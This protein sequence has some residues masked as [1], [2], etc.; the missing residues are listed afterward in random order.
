MNVL[1]TG[2]AGYIGKVVVEQLLSEGHRVRVVD[3]L[4]ASAVPGR[5]ELQAPAGAES[6]PVDITDF[7]GVRG[8]VEGQDAVVHLA[9]IPYPGGAPS[10]QLFDINCRGTYNV[11]EAAAQAGI[12]R[13]VCASSINALGFNFGVRPFPIQYLPLDEDHPTFTTDPYSFSKQVVEEI[14]RYYWRR[15]RVSSVC[16]RLPMVYSPGGWLR[17]LM[18]Q[19]QPLFLEEW[20]RLLSLSPGD[21]GAVVGGWIQKLDEERALRLREKP[22]T[23]TP[24]VRPWWEME[25]EPD[26]GRI[27]A[28]I[29]Y[30]DFW[31]VISVKDAAQSLIAGLQADYEGSHPL[32]VNEPENSL[33]LDARRL[34]EVFFPGARVETGALPEAAS[35]V[36]CRRAKDLIGFQTLDCFRKQRG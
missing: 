24:G 19:F 5:G 33:G 2:G 20:N 17:G 21:R 23:P 16:L 31:T 6:L 36:S 8:A 25:G 32:Y 15:D 30:T 26:W 4:R 28:L 7:G 10:P 12:R 34:A 1:V 35:L 9:A 22:F 29:G 13:V 14:A 18:D 11:F 3:S 27:L